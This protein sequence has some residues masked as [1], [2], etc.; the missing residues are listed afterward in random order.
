M[1]QL[2]Y[3]PRYICPWLNTRRARLFGMGDEH[4]QCVLRPDGWIDQMK[5][6][7]REAFR[8]TATHIQRGS[9]TSDLWTPDGLWRGNYYTQYTEQSDGTL[10]DGAD[11]IPIWFGEGQSFVRRPRVIRRWWDK[12]EI[13]NYIDV[14]T[15]RF[16]RHHDVWRF[17]HPDALV[18][19][20]VIELNWGGEEDYF[21]ALDL[22]LGGWLN[23]RTGRGSFIGSFSNVL[24]Q[25]PHPEPIARPQVAAP[26]KEYPVTQDWT[27]HDWGKRIDGAEVETNGANVNA[28]PTPHETSTPVLGTLKPGSRTTYWNNPY[29]SPVGSKYKWFKVIV[30]G[31]EG[32]AAQVAGLRFIDPPAPEPEPP[33]PDDTIKLTPEQYVRWQE[34]QAKIDE[35][36]AEQRALIEEVAPPL[37]PGGG[38]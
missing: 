24:I 19:E 25:Q 15:I 32:Y 8:L 26:P 38:F 35:G 1:A 5:N 6:A 7:I 33:P 16:V 30:D 4:V 11:W 3:T 22:G 23:L 14:T 34:A 21:Y 31:R 10:T 17:P 37:L 12:R 2:Y 29:P 18:L 36:S 27:S 9:D 28:R 20:D 13:A